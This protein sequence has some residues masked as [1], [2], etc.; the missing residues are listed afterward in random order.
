MK[1]IVII[2]LIFVSSHL[3][4]QQTIYD[5]IIH[6]DLQRSFILYVPD[7]YA[8][9]IAAPLVFNF[10]GYTSNALEQMYYGDFRPIADSAGFLLV[11]PMGTLDGTGNPYWNSN[12][13]GTVDDIGFTEALIDSLAENYNIDPERIYC[14]GMSNGGFMSYTLACELSNRLAA[15]AS[16]TGTMNVNQSLSCAPMHPLPVMEIHGTADFVVPYNG[17]SFMESIPNTLNYWTDF[18][19]CNNEPIITPVADIVPGDGCT[20]EHYRYTGGTDGVEVEHYK[21]INGGHTWPGSQFLS[22]NGN[23]NMDFSASEKIWVFF[24]QYDING[25]IGA[26]KLDDK[27]VVMN[28]I[29]IYPNPASHFVD[30][31]WN[32]NSVKMI[33]LFDLVGVELKIFY[34]SGKDEARLF[35]GNVKSGIYYLMFFDHQ[36]NFI[37][38]QKLIMH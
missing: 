18:N 2:I 13:G 3:F 29:N 14:T 26:T 9:D 10:H 1:S 33:R 4:C 15:I 20:A 16:V 25:R 23:T 5:T 32:G 34:V 21:V 12:W 36:N 37:G 30:V 24:S 22:G 27:A 31:D 38:S 19:E 11:H 7:S 35:I 6:D 8:P 17:N 28:R